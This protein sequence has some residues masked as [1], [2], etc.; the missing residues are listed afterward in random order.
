MYRRHLTS[1]A[2]GGEPDKD[3]DFQAVHYGVLAIQLLLVMDNST[4]PGI[5]GPKTEAAVKAYQQ[6]YVPPADGIVGPNT[7]R[8]LLMTLT[9]QATV[10]YA[11][12]DK[13][14]YG[15]RRQESADDPGAVGYSTPS[16]KGLVQ[17]NLAAHPD[18]SASS[19]FLPSYALRWAAARLRA[20]HDAYAK[21][22]ATDKLAW[23]CAVANHNSPRSADQ[24]AATGSPPSTRIAEYV[25][26]VRTLGLSA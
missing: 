21:A 22:G 5:F 20:A 23:D 24:W 10:Q 4:G 8:S 3:A 14:L 11:I 16:D 19:A 9:S 25:R 12:P 2:T 7:M 15:L 17:I 18:I 6:L 13:L 26:S 1:P